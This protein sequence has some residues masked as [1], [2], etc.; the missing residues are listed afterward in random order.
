[1]KSMKVNIIFPKIFEVRNEI[2]QDD[3]F[4]TEKIF[5]NTILMIQIHNLSN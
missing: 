5:G 1:M 4:L 3:S 2:S